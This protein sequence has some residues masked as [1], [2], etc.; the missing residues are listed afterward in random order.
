MFLNAEW[1][2]LYNILIVLLSA[3]VSFFAIPSIIFVANTR[4]LYD[5][6]EKERK[7]HEHGISRLGG[8]AIFCAFTVVSLLFARYD[9]VLSTNILLTSC[10]ML[11]AVGMKDDLAGTS[12]ATKFSIQFIVALILVGLGNVR[13]T[14]LYGVLGIWDIDYYPSIVLSVLI[15]MFFINAFNLI[16]GIDGLAGTIGIIVNLTF[17]VMFMHMEEFGLAILAFSL[18]GALVGFLFYNFSPSRIF[19]GD[20]GS[21]LV[22]LISIVLAIKFIE[23]NKFGNS[24]PRPFFLSAP[25]TAVSILIIPL[26]DTFRVFILRIMQGKSPFSADRNHIHHRILKLGFSHLQATLSLAITNILF[27]YL[28]MIFR[29]VGNGSLICLFFIICMFINWTTT[30]WIRI[31]ERRQLKLEYLWK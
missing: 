1:P 31:K 13:L 18:V 4:H 30:V 28:A 25:A 17:A 3:A 14:S 11:F 27:I 19:M 10:I 22:G 12:P 8:I 16:D 2:W 15:I 9:D 21:L 29:E 23:L 6:L 26:F 24:V 5:D 20:T 7:D